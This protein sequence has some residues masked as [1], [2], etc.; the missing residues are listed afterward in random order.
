MDIQSAIR[1]SVRKLEAQSL[2]AFEVAGMAESSLVIEA[3]KQLVH[4]FR[5]STT[6]GVAIRVVK[7]GRL[8]FASTTDISPQSIERCVVHLVEALP[9]ITPSDEAVIPK[10]G[11]KMGEL[12]EK[13]GRLPYEIKEDEKIR[14]A[15]S[16]ESA[17][18]A[19]DSRITRVQHACY[20]ERSHSLIV[21]NSNGVSA[22][23]SREISFC[24]I[25]A[26]AGEGPAAET[27]YEF[28][29][30][31][32]FDGIDAEAVAKRAALRAVAKLGGKPIKLGNANV[33]F[34][35][36]AAQSILKLA[37]PSFF[38][39]NV[40]RGKSRVA[41]SR[42]RRIYCPEI[43]IVDDG[44][45]PGGLGSFLF[46]GEGIP[47]RRTVLVRNGVVENWLYDGAR[48]AKDNVPS[49][50]SCVR[51]GLNR[52]PVIGVSNCFIKGGEKSAGE[53]IKMAGRGV[54]ITELS[55]THT[56]STISGDFSLGFE[57][58]L[59]E[60]GV[61]GAPVRAMT[62]AGNVHELLSRVT[63]VGSDLEFFGSY[64]A[65]SVLVEGLTLG[66]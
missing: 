59:I 14:R 11:E 63:G 9:H 28:A 33:L 58:M 46:D 5:R 24:E 13:R 2:D 42:G 4:S 62:V 26:I 48:A 49:T 47:K 40:Q 18:I 31:P 65:P 64:G 43:S 29:F 8:V 7:D 54:L 6:R 61:A 23:G 53:L 37:V 3:R 56:A 21:E 45:M 50:G 39:D 30:S 22:E 27:A 32:C 57:G 19:A 66:S 41:E 1:S 60:G 10:T 44:L 35:P 25:K 52:L 51:E 16:L 55:G 36:R 15:F 17:A 20:E 34:A 38:A 12:S